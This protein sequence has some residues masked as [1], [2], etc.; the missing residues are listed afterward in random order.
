MGHQIMTLKEPGE[1]CLSAVVVLGKRAKLSMCSG[2]L[3]KQGPFNF[4]M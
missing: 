3:G 2:I 4:S 1:R